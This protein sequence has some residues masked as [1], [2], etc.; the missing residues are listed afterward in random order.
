MTMDQGRADRMAE[1]VASRVGRLQAGYRADRSDAVAA[2]ARLRRGIG[3]RPGEDIELF[4]LAFENPRTEDG[5]AGSLFDE[6]S[7]RGDGITREEEAAFT[8]I[9][10]FAMH[11]QSR[12][13]ASMH[14]GG[15]SFGRSARLLGRHSG[16]RDAVRR[17]FTALGT[18]T[19]WDE[20][21]HHARGLIQQFRQHKIPLDYGQFARD[22]FDLRG[23]RAER[24]RTSW[25][26]DFYRTHHPKDDA[27]DEGSPESD[28]ITANDH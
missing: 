8:A 5:D 21:V 3:R 27:P 9:T 13:E 17:R 23:D 6:L 2:L 24:V 14:R 28:A 1:Y 7:L 22:L 15:Y 16:N 12:R 20:T 19:T 10:L 18:A 26:R 25:G 4:G 11:Q